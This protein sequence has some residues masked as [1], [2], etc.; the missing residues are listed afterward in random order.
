MSNPSN[1]AFLSNKRNKTSTHYNPMSG[2]KKKDESKLMK[3]VLK[4]SEEEYKKSLINNVKV[5]V[6]TIHDLPQV[7][8]YLASE[9]DFLEF[10]KYIDSL[11]KDNCDFGLIKIIPPPKFIENIKLTYISKIDELIGTDLE[12]K[13]Q[14]R[15]QKLN[16]LYKAE[17]RSY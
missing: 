17:V 9:I 14:F 8:E 1:N 15:I 4:L 11:W 3:Y 5:K 10:S 2:I 13:I 7:P 16:E 6:K 12:K